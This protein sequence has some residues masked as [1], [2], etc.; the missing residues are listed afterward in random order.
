MKQ[1]YAKEGKELRRKAG[2]YAHTKQFRRM[3]KIVKRQRTILGIVLREIQRKLATAELECS[4]SVWSQGQ[5][6]F[7]KTGWEAINQTNSLR[8]VVNRN[9]V[10]QLSDNEFIGMTRKDWHP[11]WF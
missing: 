4:A 10:L 6:V 7:S 2:G 11:R 9:C 1:S 5:E 8:D 3:R